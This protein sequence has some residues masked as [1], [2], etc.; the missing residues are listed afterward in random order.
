[1][2]RFLFEYLQLFSYMGSKT[3]EDPGGDF[4]MCCWIE[5]PNKEAALKWGHVLLGDYYRA[6]F[7]RSDSPCDGSPVEK[8]EIVEDEERL[9]NPPNVPVC[10]VGEIPIWDE[11]WRGHN[12]R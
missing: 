5:A 1:M 10:K 9:A 12:A 11:P 4:G 8:G 3:P 2:P 6:R 7:A